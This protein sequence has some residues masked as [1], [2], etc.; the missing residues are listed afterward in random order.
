M[1]LLAVAAEYVPLEHGVH[2]PLAAP[3]NE[4][5]AHGAHDALADDDAITF[6]HVGVEQGLPSSV[7]LDVAQDALGFIWIATDEGLVRYDGMDRVTYQ[8]TADSTSLTGNV[9]QV[10]A[11]APGGALWVG[12]DS[13]LARFDPRAR[14]DRRAARAP[15]ARL[16]LRARARS[17]RRIRR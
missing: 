9:V 8:R 10:L 12:T 11:P 6:R 15:S 16:T 13:G 17:R 4:P 14:A 3:A 1:Q 2:A 5:A 7:V